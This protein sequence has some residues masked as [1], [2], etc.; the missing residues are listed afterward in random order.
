MPKLYNFQAVVIDKNALSTISYKDFRLWS[1]IQYDD[2]SIIHLL[3]NILL[4][5]IIKKLLFS[6]LYFLNK[7]NVSMFYIYYCSYIVEFG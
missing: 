7:F 1:K 2:R 6:S 3:P 4:L 5:Y